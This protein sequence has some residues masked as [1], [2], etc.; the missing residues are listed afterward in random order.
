MTTADKT[1]GEITTE[2][3]LTGATPLKEGL[4]KA[5][6]V[7][8]KKLYV[9][10][11]GNNLYDEQFPLIEAKLKEQGCDVKT[12]IFPANT[13]PKEIEIWLKAN[14]QDWEDRSLIVDETTQN[15]IK[16]FTPP[17]EDNPRVDAYGRP[18]KNF[19]EA[20]VYYKGVLARYKEY[21]EYQTKRTQDVHLD[22]LFREM[23]E[24]S[25]KSAV[26]G[27]P[28]ETT[29][30]AQYALFMDGGASQGKYQGGEKYQREIFTTLFRKMREKELPEYIYIV[31]DDNLLDHTDFETTNNPSYRRGLDPE[32]VRR[33]KDQVTQLLQQCLLDAGALPAQIK[34]VPEGPR[35]VEGA[36]TWILVDRHSE[37]YKYDRIRITRKVGQNNRILGLPMENTL[38]D[39]IDLIDIPSFNQVGKMVQESLSERFAPVQAQL[40]Q[41]HQAT[42]GTAAT[43]EEQTRK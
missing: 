34:I 35:E 41:T 15:V 43:T 16:E 24:K 14:Q 3:Q 13:T 21:N 10:V 37:F 4:E 39:A 36:N 42:M 23:S 9:I 29:S 38:R 17:H 33:D 30:K 6:V 26:F 25:I 27:A 40:T 18:N 11:R 8:P 1:T 31:A 20:N 28:N 32:V 12:Q 19:D 5:E 22:H 7:E 2:E